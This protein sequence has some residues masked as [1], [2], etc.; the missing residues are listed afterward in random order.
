V[1]P[2]DRLRHREP[3]PGSFTR[4]LVVK[5]GSKIRSRCSGGIPGPL[6]CTTNSSSRPRTRVVSE[7][8]PPRGVA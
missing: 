3:E 5:N 2:H 7:T 6:S 8:I 4:P 1:P